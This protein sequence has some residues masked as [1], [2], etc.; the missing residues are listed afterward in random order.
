MLTQAATEERTAPSIVT[1]GDHT[2]V[3]PR[4][5]DNEPTT[6]RP[7]IDPKLLFPALH[8]VPAQESEAGVSRPRGFAMSPGGRVGKYQLGEKLGQGAFGFVFVAWD[9]DLD[10]DVAIK[11]LNP[12]HLGNPDIVQ[13]F[14]QEA[15]AAARIAHPGIVT[16]HDCGK[17]ESSIGAT[18]YLTMELLTGESLTNRLARSGRLAPGAA[19]EI[20]RQVASALDAAHRAD[21]L[22]RDLKPDNIFLVPDP[23]MPS[24]ERVKVLD[25]GLAK[26]GHTGQTRIQSVF[27]TPRYMSPE[28]CR[29]TAQ[30]DHR[31]DIYSLGCILFELVTGRPPFDGEVRQLLERHQ[32]ATPPRARTFAP[33]CPDA[34]E[35]LIA[36]LL[37]KDPMQRPQSMG[38]V[39]TA[40]QAIGGVHPPIAA[41]MLPVNVG[42][43]TGEIIVPAPASGPRELPAPPAAAHAVAA[44]P[45][46]RKKLIGAAAAVFLLAALITS[47][48]LARARTPAAAQPGILSGPNSLTKG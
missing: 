15:R 5:P 29:S 38:A 33:D 19:I 27:G 25:F 7:T 40:L 37:A 2:V 13:R 32:R 6:L 36:E 23:A 43:P 18:A 35:A 45:I 44:P 24:G 3:E 46:S 47:V 11:V 42:W 4:D 41:T 28:Q 48:S 16:M 17:V 39:Q 10:R 9:P 14:L 31:S 22:H 30:V 8:T 1:D 34:L 26:L 20:A 21:V 12:T